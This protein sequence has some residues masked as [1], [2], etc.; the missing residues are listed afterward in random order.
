[1]RITVY[2]PVS[3][4]EE[5]QAGIGAVDLHVTGG[6]V[7]EP[8]TANIVERRRRNSEH[9]LGVRVA[10][11]ADRPNRRAYQHLRIVRAVGL[12]AGLAF[13]Y[14]GRGMF[15]HERPLFVGVTLQAGGVAEL[16]LPHLAPLDAAVRLVAVGAPH[17]VFAYPVMERL[18][19]I[20]TSLHVA[21][22]AEI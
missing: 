21:A 16:G 3:L 7:L 10:F 22:E 8:G 14:H 20:G 6:A 19:E 1:M 2:A 11:Q 18:G 4:P 13:A 12:V 5:D 17:R 9:S 15:E